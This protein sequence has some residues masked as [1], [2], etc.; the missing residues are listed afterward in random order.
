MDQN[1]PGTIIAPR[2]LGVG[3]VGETILADRIC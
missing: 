2:V 1:G 3:G